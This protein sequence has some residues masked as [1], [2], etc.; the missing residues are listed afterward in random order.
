MVVNKMELLARKH[1]TTTHELGM[2]ANMSIQHLN[3]LGRGQVDI[4]N[5][6]VGTLER[7]ARALQ[8]DTETVYGALSK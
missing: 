3:A 4:S 2:R 1:G 6:K 5:V 7:I 8:T